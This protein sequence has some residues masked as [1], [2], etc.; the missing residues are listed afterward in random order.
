MQMAM[1]KVS[2]S[3][4]PHGDIRWTYV[5][6]QLHT[7]CNIWAVSQLLEWKHYQWSFLCFLTAP[8]EFQLSSGLFLSEDHFKNTNSFT[9]QSLVVYRIGSLSQI[10]SLRGPINSILF[11]LLMFLWTFILK[12]YIYITLFVSLALVNINKYHSILGN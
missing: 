9:F 6:H 3:L 1:K 4:L 10:I 7:K 5:Y 11:S 8:P 12:S 2:V